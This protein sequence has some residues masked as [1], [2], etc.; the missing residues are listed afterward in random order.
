MQKL[1]EICIKR[2]V[3]AA[4]LVLALVVV[5]AASYFKLGVDRL[6]S[7][8]VPTVT[9]RVTLRGASPEE[10]ETQIVQKIENAVNTVEGIEEL[11][12]ISG[13]GECYITATFKL[14]RDIDVATQ[15]V[16]DRISN[17]LKDLPDQTDPPVVSKVDNDS[18]PVLTLSLAGPRSLRELTEIADKIVR[19]Q[20][21]RSAGV[22][23][24]Y[25]YGGYNRAINIWI[26]PDK[27]ASYEIPITT[28]KDAIA[29]QN[30]DSAGGNVTGALQE[31]VLR[32]MGRYRGSSD[33]NNLIVTTINGAPIRIKDIGW[34]EDGAK[35][36][37]SIARLNGVPTVN[38]AVLRQ[39]KTNTIEVIEAA[40]A[41]L[42]KIQ[43]QL[44]SDVKL[45]TI[46]DQSNYIYA[47]LHEINTHLI[48]GS[49]FASLVVL[50]FM[51]SW[52]STIIAAVAIPAS[53]ISTFGMMW[54]LHFTLNSVTMLALVLMVGVVIDDAIVVL[55][56][57]FRFVEEKKLHP[58]EAAR[59]ATAE[60]GLA[61]LATT[62]SLVVIFVPV[63]FMS[64]VAG[65]FL[66]Q[67][68][69]TAAVAVLVSMLV[70]FTLTPMMAARMLRADDA[71]KGSA[72][73]HAAS[74][75]GFYG[76]IDGVYTFLLTWSMKFRFGV[77][78]V[79][80]LVM[81]SSYPLYKMVRQ[82]FLPS[83]VDEAEFSVRV[84]GREGVSLAAMDDAVLAIDE[85][86]R[87]VRGV[88]TTLATSGGGF[89]GAVNSGDI[90]VRIAPHEVRTFS[91][92]RLWH[93]IL[94]GHPSQAFAGN[95]S[96]LDV[97]QEVRRKI[98]RFKDVRCQ[99]RNFIPFQ[100]GSSS[101][102]VDFLIRGP[103]LEV[104]ANASEKLREI[105]KDLGGII[106][107]D[108]TLKLDKP[109][110]RV[111]PDRQRAA[112]LG[113]DA[114][115]LGD[116]M[117]IMIGGETQV[118]LFHDESINE[119]YDVDLRLDP[120]SRAKPTDIPN[121]YLPRKGGGLVQLGNLAHVELAH[122]PGRI[123]RLDRQRTA[124][125]RGGVA[126]G[127]SLADRLQALKDAVPQL[128]LPQGYTT[129]II[130][131]GKDLE[132]MLFEFLWAFLGS[133]I[134]MYMI[135]AANYESLIHPF[136][137]LLS[138]PLSIPFALLSL[139]LTGGTLNIYSALGILVLFGVVKKN[140]ILQIDHMNRLRSEGM[141]RLEAII[142]GN[143]DRLRPILMT[144]L[145]LVA[146]MMPLAVGTGPGAEERRAVA[147]V[148][149][150]GQTLSLLL[151]LLVTPVA[152]SIF[153]D[154]AALFRKR[155][156]AS[157]HEHPAMPH[158]ERAEPALECA[159][160]VGN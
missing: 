28:V 44:P 107:T 53:V 15:D 39:S 63:S 118:S 31:Q 156:P 124:N 149:I 75:R 35:E 98:A 159:P 143:R 24:V 139:Y 85:Q 81:A 79:A 145:A 80:I 94:H 2:P 45:V 36:V 155:A 51:R 69:L 86:I 37:R 23:R 119:D 127:Y 72:M 101:F 158:R 109:E 54:L 91:L 97:M 144:T 68:G 32:T 122:I 50:A 55:E 147:I 57:I 47:A 42:A 135:L 27:L 12:S 60:I 93:E 70:S 33:F 141:P 38:L 40:K 108:T 115:D 19:V 30:A 73:D 52:R 71:H 121:L 140:S 154:I 137:I 43:D 49:I 95:Y 148:V 106:D 64:S 104:L 77:A 87:Q 17:I 5:G 26:D 14:N 21:E 34:A 74:R 92:E 61:V 134:L 25:I 142:Q 160:E 8:D 29:R 111:W 4:M 114:Q 120:R 46:R 84:I 153:D 152:Y 123:D 88:E 105:S 22:G 129:R 113:V 48:L 13:T 128:D 150:G 83:D 133:I 59:A 67:F 62:L 138:I 20:L 3:F 103:E 136:T 116:A 151:T 9:V 102:D 130:G 65:R 131:R 125:L 18:A 6:P 126:P 56:N 16:R 58:F 100:T 112:D 96:Q 11:R 146:G 99:V 132:G 7:V 90:Y 1:A 157:L 76:L 41:N 110:L 10:M 89:L 78:L 82:E 117:R 66:Y